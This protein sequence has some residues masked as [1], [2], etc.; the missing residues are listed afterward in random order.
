MAEKTGSKKDRETVNDPGDT[1]R[2]ETLDL[3]REVIALE[4]EGLEE[5]HRSVGPQ[6]AEAVEV[7]AAARRENGLEE[8]KLVLI[9][10]ATMLHQARVRRGLEVMDRSNGEIWAKLDAGTPEFFQRIARSAVSFEQILDNLRQAAQ[11]RPIVIQSL[12]MRIQDQPPAAEEIAAYCQRLREIVEDGGQI[13]L[14]Q[15]YTVSRPPA[16]SFVAPLADAEVDA[17][18]QRIQRATGLKAEPFYA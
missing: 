1:S 8:L 5:L 16:E 11:S 18:V 4:I 17:L 12:F 9:T 3:G 15:V 7:C 14:V 10:N 6:F 13:K 2:D